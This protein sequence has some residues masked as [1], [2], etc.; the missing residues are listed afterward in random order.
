M[1]KNDE[2]AE[3]EVNLEKWLF[4]AAVNLLQPSQRTTPAEWARSN[5]VYPPS[6]AVPGPR[7]PYLTPYIIEPACMAS[8]TVYARIVFMSGAQVSKTEMLLD[9]IGQR[10]DQKPAPILYVGPTLDFVTKQFE[11][12]LMALLDEAPRLMG[13]VARGKRLSKTR[14]LVAGVPLRLAHAGSS[15]ALKSDPAALALIDEFDG[16]LGNVNRQGGPLGLVEAR[17][18]NFADFCCVV[19]S[20][21]RRGMVD[22]E[23]DEASGLEF[24]AVADT[25]DVRESPVLGVMATGHSTSLVLA[26]PAL[27]RIFRSAIR[28]YALA[29]ECEP[30]RGGAQDIH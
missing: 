21:P 3:L 9:I 12:R 6:A 28:S 26:V 5:R 18:F 8:E 13:K 1:K 29:G 10:L 22:I 30:G 14:K 20:T 15:T 23:K 7:D 4:E 24:W 11:P 17:G 27:W 25:E 16:M 2:G 19:T